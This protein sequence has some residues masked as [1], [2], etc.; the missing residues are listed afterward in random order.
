MYSFDDYEGDIIYGLWRAG[1]NIDRVDPG[2][3]REYYDDGFTE[4]TAVMEEINKQREE[5]DEC[6]QRMWSRN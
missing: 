6:M 1:Y 3:L 4:E 2:I 5:K